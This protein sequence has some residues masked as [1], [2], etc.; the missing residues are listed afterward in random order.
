MHCT[1][2][3]LALEFYVVYEYFEGSFNYVHTFIIVINLVHILLRLRV[4]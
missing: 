4:K 3:L 1:D 2:P